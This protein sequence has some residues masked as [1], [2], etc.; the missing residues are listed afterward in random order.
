MN[1]EGNVTLKLS[2]LTITEVVTT[3]NI[4]LTTWLTI[5]SNKNVGF[6]STVGFVAL[7]VIRVN[8]LIS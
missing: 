8:S 4:P 7:K 5:P 2:S 3:V 6:L 1:Y